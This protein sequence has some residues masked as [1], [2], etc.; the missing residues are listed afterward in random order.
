MTFL[1]DE[2]SFF[3]PIKMVRPPMIIST[4]IRTALS[5]PVVL[6]VLQPSNMSKRELYNLQNQE[7]AK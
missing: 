7:Y 3:L 6:H 4:Y 1:L 5:F 2:L